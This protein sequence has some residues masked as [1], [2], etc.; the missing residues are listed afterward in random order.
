MKNLYKLTIE[1][2]SQNKQGTSMLGQSVYTGDLK[3]VTSLMEKNFRKLATDWEKETI[4]ENEMLKSTGKVTSKDK[5]SYCT[6]HGR[7]DGTETNYKVIKLCRP[8][9]EEIHSLCLSIEKI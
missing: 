8:S 4:K 6:F 7:N 1:H 9:I 3:D 2:T 5:L